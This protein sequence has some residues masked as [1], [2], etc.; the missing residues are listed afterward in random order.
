[1][2]KINVWM[3]A[4]AAA[5]CVTMNSC[6]QGVSTD[7]KLSSQIDSLSYAVGI[8]VGNNIKASAATFPGED[9][10]KI[11]LVIKGLLTVLKDSAAQ[12][13]T[14]EDASAYINAYIMKVQQAQ[15]EAELKV[16]QD[17]LAANRSKEGVITTASG[18]QYKVIT[19]GTGAK[20]T[21]K[22]KVRC[23]YTGRLLDGTVFDSSVQ[24]GQPAEFE[25]GQVIP[26]WQEVLQLMPVGSKFQVWIPSNL[27]YGTQ[28][29]GPIKPNSTLEFEIELL[30]IVK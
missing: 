16:G 25:V 5:A 20:P 19:E 13:M 29:A 28:G 23:H 14:F 18:L 26:G 30:E 4:A 21:V 22:D 10:L 2:K 9:S 1:M 17:F 12:K 7:A 11:D 27:A 3:M 8:N 24:R 6:N 15:A